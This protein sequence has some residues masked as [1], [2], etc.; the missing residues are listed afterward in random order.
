MFFFYS[1]RV[2]PFKFAVTLGGFLGGIGYH[3]AGKARTIT[4]DNLRRSFPEKSDEEIRD[5]AKKVFINQGK[6]AFEVFNY[7][8]FS[9]ED[10]DGLV[11]VENEEGYAKACAAGKGV[12]MA[13]GHCASW[14]LLG[15]ALSARGFIINVIAKRIYIEALNTML[16]ELRNSKGLKII[17]RSDSDSA[18]KMIKALRAKETLALLIDQD[19][20]VPGIFVDFFG[21]PSWTP[22]AVAVLALKT[23]AP[24]IV[25]LDIRLSDDKHKV[26]ITGP[27]E[28]IRT[29]DYDKDVIENTKAVTKIIED[30]IRK[31]P[32]QWVWM[33]ER[34]KTKQAK[35]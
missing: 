5:I 24:V 12:L 13:S 33:H 18:R 3:L 21:R 27:I 14:E 16:L 2:V 32:D 10:L 4:E 25:A 9:G 29:G 20:E 15:A 6:N 31:Y 28:T 1:V 19:T 30:H 17:F 26:V 22:S 34:W 11:S 35:E 8:Q 23:G 7:P